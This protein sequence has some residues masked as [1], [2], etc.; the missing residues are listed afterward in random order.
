[1]SQRAD[2]QNMSKAESS[3]KAGPLRAITGCHWAYS[4]KLT[5]EFNPG[6]PVALSAKA[7]LGAQ[8]YIG[9]GSLPSV[10]TTQPHYAPPHTPEGSTR[11]PSNNTTVLS[12]PLTPPERMLLPSQH[13]PPPLPPSTMVQRVPDLHTTGYTSILCCLLITDT[14]K[15]HHQTSAPHTI[16]YKS[17]EQL[18]RHRSGTVLHLFNSR[19]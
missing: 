11:R 17:F 16:A 2:A 10:E 9:L 6:A 8:P 5:Y 14:Q 13:I 4:G 12:N 18:H 15:K 19:Q 1:M 3:I 7:P